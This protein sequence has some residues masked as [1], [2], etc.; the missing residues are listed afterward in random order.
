MEPNGVVSVPPFPSEHQRAG[1]RARSVVAASP[2]LHVRSPAADSTVSLAA[3]DPAGDLLLLVAETDPLAS[4]ARTGEVAGL[5]ACAEAAWVSPAPLPDRVLARLWLQGDLAEVA[6]TDRPLAAR[7]LARSAGLAARA[8]QVADVA[9]GETVLRL[10]VHD[11]VLVDGPRLLPVPVQAWRAAGADPLAVASA[12]FVAHLVE[13]HPAELD[14]L[15]PLAARALPVSV[16]DRAG[17]P[18]LV[19]LDRWGLRWRCASP[20][21]ALDVRLDFPRPLDDVAELG[22]ALRGLTAG[23]GGGCCAVRDCDG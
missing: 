10:V 3:V 6:G 7:E 13:G 5:P 19:G 20:G 21:G 23:A 12:G 8:R 17:R 11:V 18:V 14:L 15:A 1:E 22:S 16:A 4:A 2:T 9:P